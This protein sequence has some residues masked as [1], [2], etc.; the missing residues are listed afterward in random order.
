[1]TGV[2]AQPNVSDDYLNARFCF[3]QCPLVQDGSDPRQ[4]TAL[5]INSNL[6]P[7]YLAPAPRPSVRRQMS[8][9]T[10]ALDH[11]LAALCGA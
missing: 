7:P 3:P 6:E 1:M 2:A 8:L 5:R 9:Y 4:T 10:G 11:E